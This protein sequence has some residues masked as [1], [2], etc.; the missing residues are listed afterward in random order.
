[1]NRDKILMAGA[2]DDLI[3]DGHAIVILEDYVLNLDTWLARHPG[4]R[5]VILHMV[6]K[7]ATDEIHA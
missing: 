2:I 4:G 5:L 3:A 6:G 7:D 1:M